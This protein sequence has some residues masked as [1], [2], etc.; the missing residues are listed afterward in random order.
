M[1]ITVYVLGRI[2]KR[3]WRPC[4]SEVYGHNRRQIWMNCL[5]TPTS[6]PDVRRSTSDGRYLQKPTQNPRGF[7]VVYFCP[8][9]SS[10]TEVS[11]GP[12]PDGRQNCR[13]RRLPSLS[14][15]SLNFERVNMRPCSLPSFEPGWFWWVRCCGGFN[16]CLHN[17][18]N[19]KVG[20]LSLSL[21]G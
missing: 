21:L 20:R 5:P 16:S 13:R 8:P 2:I 19:H 6:M 18:M 12:L 11:A 1:D 4:M 7:V 14:P 15:L 17:V 9:P 10:G 3:I